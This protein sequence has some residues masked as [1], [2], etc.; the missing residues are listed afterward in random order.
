M[1]GTKGGAATLRAVLAALLMVAACASMGAQKVAINLY[2][3][4]SDN[5][6]VTWEA[7]LDAFTKAEPSVQVNLQYLASGTGGQGGVDKLIAAVQAGVKSVDIDVLETSDNDIAR[8][9][10]EAGDKSLTSIT[11]KEV[12]NLKNVLQKS[13]LGR[14]YAVPFRGTTVLVAYNSDRVTNPPKTYDE[15]ITWIKAHKGRLAYN[16]PTTG[17]SGESF[18]ISSIYNSLPADA[19][20]STDAKWK[21]QWDKGFELLK[22]LQPYLYSA[23]GKVQYPVKNQGTIDLLAN[24]EVDMIPAWADMILDQKSR[25]LLPASI[26]LTQ[27]EPAFNGGIQTLTVPAL[28]QHKDAAYKLLNFVTSPEGQSIFVRSMKAIPIVPATSL[29]KDTIDMLAGLQIKGFR[30][31]TIGALEADLM[32]RW[33]TDIAAAR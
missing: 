10:K 18:V 5:V 9:L 14:D 2:T 25:G 8:I 16:D 1:S 17:G 7:V 33:Q 29:S 28:S 22:S 12:P 24:G 20:T 23:S 26:K 27:I 4:G 30:P 13:S 31:Y 32:K 19:L 3:G 21:A 6:R 15:L 11:T